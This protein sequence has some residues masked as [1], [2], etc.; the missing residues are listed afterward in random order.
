M[1]EIAVNTS[2]SAT[3]PI[4]VTSHEVDR[5]ENMATYDSLCYLRGKY[6]DCTFS[7]VV[8]SDW[9]QPGTDLRQWTSKEGRTGERLVSEFD[10]LV[11]RRPGYEVADLSTYG[12]RFYWMDLPN[13]FKLVESTAS[14]TEI[15]KRATHNWSAECSESTTLSSLDGLVATGVHAYILRHK[16]Y[17][18]VSWRMVRARDEAV[19]EV[20]RESTRE[21]S[22]SAA[23]SMRSEADERPS[24]RFSVS[25]V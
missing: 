19:R 21:R 15:R 8:G 16:L 1:C 5:D 24:E 14:S 12:P 23:N 17:R 6:P 22:G 11:L 9:L 10:F 18:R 2:V 20:V 25:S 13:G 7:F 4:M 3:F